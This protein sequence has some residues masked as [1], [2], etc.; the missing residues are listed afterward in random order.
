MNLYKEWNPS[1]PIETFL[2]NIE[3]QQVFATK[4]AGSA[5]INTAS[6]ARGDRTVWAAQLTNISFRC[7]LNCYSCSVDNEL[8][9]FITY[10][11][12]VVEE[13]NEPFILR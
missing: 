8:F 13:F 4:A 10:Y 6:L 5:K 11:C 9:A 2:L 12:L 3:T 1:E 7:S